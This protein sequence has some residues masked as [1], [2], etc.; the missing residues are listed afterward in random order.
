MI[1]KGENRGRKVKLFA[2]EA[3][4]REYEGVAQ[5]QSALA[6]GYG[7]GE[8]DDVLLPAPPPDR[9]VLDPDAPLDPDPLLVEPVPAVFGLV[10]TLQKVAVSSSMQMTPVVGACDAADWPF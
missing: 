7:H 3:R 9:E 10:G 4:P 8:V 2:P 6:D 5:S 1:C